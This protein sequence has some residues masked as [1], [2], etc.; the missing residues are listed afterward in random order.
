MY[1]WTLQ[2]VDPVPFPHVNHQYWYLHN[3]LQPKSLKKNAPPNNRHPQI[4]IDNKH[5]MNPYNNIHY[6][7][8]FS[9]LMLTVVPKSVVCTMALMIEISW[10]LIVI[11]VH[12]WYTITSVLLQP[13]GISL[14]VPKLRTPLMACTSLQY[15]EEL[16][17]DME[18]LES[19]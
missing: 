6:T 7:M 2:F 5:A 18:S 13:W 4:I 10:K 11:Q 1:F 3:T 8:H 17:K 9:D 14:C 15:T 16:L 19:I 12:L